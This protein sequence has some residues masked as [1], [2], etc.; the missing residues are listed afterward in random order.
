MAG[1]AIGPMHGMPIGLKDIVD[2]EGITTTCHSKI[3]R[4]NVPDTDATCAAKLAAAGS[5]LMGKMTTHE[6]ADGG[7]SFDL[8]KPPARNP[9]NS[10]AF[11]G[12]VEQRHWGGRRG[13]GDHVRYRH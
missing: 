12:R 3:L 11:H 1:K 7:P 4:D 10:G 5:V 2:T 13:R 9:W 6:F 8:P